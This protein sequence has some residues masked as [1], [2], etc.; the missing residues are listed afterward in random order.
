MEIKSESPEKDVEEVPKRIFQM[1][2]S[3][4]DQAVIKLKK[5]AKK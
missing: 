5:I 3:L 2:N 1:R 4:M